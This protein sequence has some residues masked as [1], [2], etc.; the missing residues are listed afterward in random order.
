MLYG[1]NVKDV[2]I[3]RCQQ[4]LLGCV[5]GVIL[6]IKNIESMNVFHHLE[7]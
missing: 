7:W 2:Q 3:K 4:E 6:N 1:E 5:S